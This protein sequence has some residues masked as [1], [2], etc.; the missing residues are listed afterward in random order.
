MIGYFLLLYIMEGVL[1]LVRSVEPLSVIYPA[2]VVVVV[3]ILL[4]KFFNGGSFTIPAG[5]SLESKCA[6][7]TGGNSGIGA[8]TARQLSELGCSVIIGARD[9]KTAEKVIKKTKQAHPSAKVDYIF[10]DLASR[11]SI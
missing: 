4:N 5:L 3:L 2:L 9:R 11:E 8:E 10:L 1:D 7:V 6:V